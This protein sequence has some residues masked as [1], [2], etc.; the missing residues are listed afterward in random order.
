MGVKLGSRRAKIR[1]LGKICENIFILLFKTGSAARSDLLVPQLNSTAL[2]V[3]TSRP[4]RRFSLSPSPRV[5]PR[6]RGRA[7]LFLPTNYSAAGGE[8]ER[9]AKRKSGGSVAERESWRVRGG[10]NKMGDG[11]VGNVGGTGR[12]QKRKRERRER[13][14]CSLRERSVS[15]S[16]SLLRPLVR[17]P[18]LCRSCFDKREEG[19]ANARGLLWA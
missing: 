13:A 19:D 1:K 3:I 14:R 8:R 5:G 9:G 10:V 12:E 17:W 16:P 18:S 2:S 6:R 4:K 11:G 15:P 7:D